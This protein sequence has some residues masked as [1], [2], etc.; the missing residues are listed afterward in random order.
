[1]LRF[2]MLLAAVALLLAAAAGTVSAQNATPFTGRETPDPSLCTIA[3]RSAAI[4]TPAAANGT[5]AAARP[6]T[7]QAVSEPAGQAA[8]AATTAAITSTARELYACLNGGDPLRALTLF[9][10]AGAAQFLAV[11][12]DLTPSG[13]AATPTPLALENRIALVAITD[14]RLLPDGRVFALVTQDDPNRPPAGPEPVFIT[15]AK[16][17]AGWLVDDIRFLASGA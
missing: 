6:A 1:M 10:D 15:F 3:P 16:H 7:P 13:A 14:V 9:T 8:D 11:R 2:T 4:L 5:P 17:G 12:P